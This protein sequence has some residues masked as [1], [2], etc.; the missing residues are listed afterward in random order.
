[1]KLT[2]VE[3]RPDSASS[4]RHLLRLPFS[5]FLDSGHG[6]AFAGRYDVFTAA[7]RQ[8]LT[9]IGAETEIR[10]ADGVVR[11]GDDP[12]ELLRRA[13]GASIGLEEV[14]AD[15]VCREQ[16][17][18]KAEE[19]ARMVQG[20]SALESQGVDAATFQWLVERSYHELMAGPRGRLW[21]E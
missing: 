17:R 1:M 16:A 21:S 10:S 8:T 18:K 14:D 3:Y 7:P 9:T 2:E 15:E 6:S 5:V 4:F 20:T 13:L 19:L 12:L 11:S